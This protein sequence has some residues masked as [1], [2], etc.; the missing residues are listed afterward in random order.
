M[1][2][3][4][5][6]KKVNK[7]TQNKIALG[8][9]KTDGTLLKY[10][11]KEMFEKIEI[12]SKNFIKL[13]IKQGFRIGITAPSSPEW[14]INYLAIQKIKATAV[15]IDSSL[16]KEEIF[17]L[18]ENSDLRAVIF[19]N[20]IHNKI[21]IIENM[22]N[23]KLESFGRLF[24][25]SKTNKCRKTQIKENTNIS[26]I[27]YSSGTT[28]TASGIMH[29]SDSLINTTKMTIKTV[30]LKRN[31]VFLGMLPNSH[32]YGVIT[33]ILRTSVFIIFSI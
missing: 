8:L 20:S 9:V 18:V 14:V 22:P 26:T 32:I 6:I 16:E 21:G 33:Q 13:G 10:T 31:S 27:I 19:N 1:N 7:N 5:E 4:E 3:Y 12:C 23:I 2:I 25:D 29:N 30:G 15:L 17:K 24:A 28:K 11:Y